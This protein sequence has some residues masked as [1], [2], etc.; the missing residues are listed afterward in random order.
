MKFFFFFTRHRDRVY[1]VEKYVREMV[2][3]VGG[4]VSNVSETTMASLHVALQRCAPP[5]DSFLTWC[6]STFGTDVPFP[7]AISALFK[8]L[9]KSSPVCALLPQWESLDA[10]YKKLVDNMPIKQSP[11]DLLLLQQSCPLLFDTISFVEGDHLPSV[12]CVLIKDLLE[13]AK[14]P[15][16]VASLTDADSEDLWHVQDLEYFPCLP[17]VR[18]RGDFC[19]DTTSPSNICT[20]KSTRHPTLLPGIFLVHCKHGMVS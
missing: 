9:G 12:L 15:F 7:R 3:Q 1:L 16:N 10:L 4:D 14:A 17:V 19:F 13:K 6:I 2:Y 20:K 18:S 8:A 5:L 11:G